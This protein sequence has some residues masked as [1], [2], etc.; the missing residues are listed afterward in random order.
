MSLAHSLLSPELRFAL[1]KLQSRLKV[2]ASLLTPWRFEA[3]RFTLPHYDVLSVAPRADR[4]ANELFRLEGE[5]QP[6]GLRDLLRSNAALVSPMVL[7]GALRVPFDVHTVVPLGRPLDDIVARYDRE[8]RRTLKKHRPGYAFTHV[9]DPEQIARIDAEMLVPYARNRHGAEARIPPHS[10]VRKIALETGRMDLV[11]C[12]GVPV[13]CHLG[14]TLNRSGQRHFITLRFGYPEAVFSDAKRLREVNAMNTF[15]ALEWA[16]A[17]QLDCYDMGSAAARP[18]DGLLQWKRRRDGAI[19]IFHTEEWLSVRPPPAATPAFFWDHPTFAV[20][21]GR[22]ELHLGVAPGV[23]DEEA[24]ARFKQFGFS[25]LDRV[26]VHA[27]RALA[28]KTVE[29][30]KA[31]FEGQTLKPGEII[32]QAPRPLSGVVEPQPAL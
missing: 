31:I 9:T 20:A 24:L 11:T 28:P 10:E 25:G 3:R 6:G 2:R 27:P 19:D 13:A 22:L 4:H 16:H 23:T 17:Q 8:L 12:E 7:P 21:E 1:R 26:R 29:T 32:V 30:V 14:Y 18:D 5:G 15:L